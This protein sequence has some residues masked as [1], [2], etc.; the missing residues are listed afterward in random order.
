M[1]FLFIASFLLLISFLVFF[2][3][4]GHY[5]VAKLFGTA[6]DRFSIGFGKPIWKR[7]DRSGTEWTIS[8]VPLGGYVK[9]M[10]DAGAASNPDQSLSLIHI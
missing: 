6:V 1:A 9:F 4:M 7:V 8:R 3:E 2:H 5:S 10:G